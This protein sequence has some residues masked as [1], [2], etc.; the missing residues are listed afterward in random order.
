[1]HIIL[2]THIHGRPVSHNP[3]VH[4]PLKKRCFTVARE[5]SLGVPFLE[6]AE[7][8]PEGLAAPRPF[9][10]GSFPKEISNN[11]TGANDLFS[12]FTAN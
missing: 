10:H 5:I 9:N 11:Q 1:M 7:W 6:T 12:Q 8:R 2:P 3:K 4:L